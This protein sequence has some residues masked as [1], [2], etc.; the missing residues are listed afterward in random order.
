MT[1]TAAGDVCDTR[2]RGRRPFGAGHEAVL[3]ALVRLCVSRSVGHRWLESCR[4]GGGDGKKQTS[5]E[6]SCY[7]VPS[8][9]TAFHGCRPIILFSLVPMQLRR[10]V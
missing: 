9:E 7:L 8:L 5:R 1:A 2:G 10:L 3:L 4:A 6:P